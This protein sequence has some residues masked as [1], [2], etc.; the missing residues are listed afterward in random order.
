M[1]GSA[2]Q[3][4]ISSLASAVETGAMFANKENKSNY[5]SIMN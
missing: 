3:I 4:P 2:H 1:Y 5:H